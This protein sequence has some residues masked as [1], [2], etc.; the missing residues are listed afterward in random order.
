MWEQ[1]GLSGGCWEPR[2]KKPQQ[3]AAQLDHQSAIRIA[4]SLCVCIHACVWLGSLSTA[5]PLFYDVWTLLH[6]LFKGPAI[7]QVRPEPIS[8]SLDESIKP[9]SFITCVFITPAIALCSQPVSFDCSFT[10][11]SPKGELLTLHRQKKQTN[12]LIGKR[13]CS[14]KRRCKTTSFTLVDWTFP[15]GCCLLHSTVIDPANTS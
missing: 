1:R 5:E 8:S 7:S 11:S 9:F 13:Y 4:N 3:A 2:A 12:M 10:Q 6:S 14:V 15:R